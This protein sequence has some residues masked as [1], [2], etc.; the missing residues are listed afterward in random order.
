MRLYFQ[1]P[2]VTI[3]QGDCLEVL[4]KLPE[5][6]V[7]LILTDP[8][9]H[10]TKKANI[11]GDRNFKNDGSYLEWLDS[12]AEQWQRVLAPNCSLYCFA[13]PKM[14]AKVEVMLGERFNVLASIT[15]TKPNEPGYDGWK[16][17]TKKESLR[18]WYLH[19]ER[20]IFA[21]AKSEEDRR[22]PFSSLLQKTRKQ[23]GLS[24]I[25]L[26]GAIGEYG[27]VNHG[28][29]VSNWESGR[30]IPDREQYRKIKEVL[31][32][33]EP[34]VPELPDYEEIVRPF[35]VTADVPYTDVWDFPSVRPYPGKHPAEKPLD[36]IE[37]IIKA[38]SYPGDLVLDC[39]AGSG[40][41]GQAAKKLNRQATL[42]EIEERWC[43]SIYQRCVSLSESAPEPKKTTKFN[44]QSEPLFKQL[45][46]KM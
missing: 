4:R 32:E 23:A 35:Y 21:E 27:E 25:Q 15:W 8:P 29:A 40:V 16:Q 19:S 28:G 12:V 17:K 46:E 38:S 10:A 43:E 41:V 22:S 14:A 2:Q 45:T 31:S 5:S 6:S 36:L 39:F 3:Y 13:S 20:V 9:Y 18:N 26:T 24:T 34:E 44:W 11:T 7:N 42:I 37:H 33:L 30:N 1:S